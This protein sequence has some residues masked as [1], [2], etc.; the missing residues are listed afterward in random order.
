M[1]DHILVVGQIGV[2]LHFYS[3]STL[4]ILFLSQPA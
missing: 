2:N 3:D 1:L 4:E